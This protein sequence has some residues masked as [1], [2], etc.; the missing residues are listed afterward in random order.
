MSFVEMLPIV[1]SLSRLEKLQLIQL[2]ADDL[3][4]VEESPHLIAGR[5]Y[6]LWSPDRAYEAADVLMRELEAEK[7]SDRGHG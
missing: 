1:R 6:P 7:C 5:S 4:Q 3:A 2:L